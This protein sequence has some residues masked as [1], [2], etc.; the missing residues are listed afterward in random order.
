METLVEWLEVELAKRAW[1]PADLARAAHLP[2]A[3][4]SNILNFN[5]KAGSDVCN[6]IAKALDEPPEKIF[7]LAGILPPLPPPVEE[8]RE[9]IGILRN[10]PPDLRVVALR[11][12]RS[13]LPE[14]APPLSA[15]AI[16]ET[17]LPHQI[18]DYDHPD[19]APDPA[20]ELLGELWEQV[21]DWKKRD[22]VDQINAAVE[23]HEQEIERKKSEKKVGN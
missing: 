15:P 8:E 20:I 18:Q 17:Q 16:D 2:D 1:K 6:A 13:L 21:P 14:T 11:M 5:R 19:I 23:E 12:L 7:R 10:L 4:I 9:A 22:I 3:T